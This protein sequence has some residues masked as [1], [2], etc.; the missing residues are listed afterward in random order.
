MY[1]YAKSN[2]G[3]GYLKRETLLVEEALPTLIIGTFRY[4]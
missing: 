2:N 4:N 3:T 1:V